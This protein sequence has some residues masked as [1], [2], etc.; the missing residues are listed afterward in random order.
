MFRGFLWLPWL[1]VLCFSVLIEGDPLVLVLQLL[2]DLPLKLSVHLSL[3][4]LICTTLI[5][6]HSIS[7]YHR[8]R[9]QLVVLLLPL[10]PLV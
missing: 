3:R 2:A 10:L 4:C 6:F 5:A 8:A 7:F 1:L 9:K